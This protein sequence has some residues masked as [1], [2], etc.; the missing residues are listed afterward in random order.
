ML[1]NIFSHNLDLCKNI[2]FASAQKSFAS[3]YINCLSA[4]KL[5]SR[6][7]KRC[8]KFDGIKLVKKF[9]HALKGFIRNVNFSV[10]TSYNV[11][12]SRNR[13]QLNGSCI[14]Y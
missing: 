3:K 10:I 7:N 11:L 1:L 6:E 8:A 4:R 12:I 14:G 5:K 9:E 2:S 13:I